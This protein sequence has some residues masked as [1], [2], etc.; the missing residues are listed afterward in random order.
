MLFLF[1]VPISRLAFR[2]HRRFLFLLDPLMVT[3]KAVTHVL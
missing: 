1:N 2:A 3:S